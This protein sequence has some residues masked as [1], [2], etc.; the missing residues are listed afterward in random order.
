MASTQRSVRRDTMRGDGHTRRM[1]FSG[2]NVV[3]DEEGYEYPVDD[4]G[5][6]YVPLDAQTIS[7]IEDLENVQKE[8]RN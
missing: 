6:I 1:R 3:Y 4:E 5:R 8:T 7:E 2:L